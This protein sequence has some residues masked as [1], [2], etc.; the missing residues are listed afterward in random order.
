MVG[1]IDYSCCILELWA[2]A[3]TPSLQRVPEGYT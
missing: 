1:I 3:N 2:K